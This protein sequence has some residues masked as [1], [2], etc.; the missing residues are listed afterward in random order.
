VSVTYTWGWNPGSLRPDHYN[1][2][3]GGGGGGGGGGDG[4]DDYVKFENTLNKF[5]CT[6][7]LP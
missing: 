4:G 1:K 7:N 3:D 5:N 2:H 6:Q